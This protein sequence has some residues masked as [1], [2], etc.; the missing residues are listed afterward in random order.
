MEKGGKGV[1][2]TSW[3]M[4]HDQGPRRAWPI[5][6]DAASRLIKKA[7]RPVLVVGSAIEE[8]DGLIDIAVRVS[9]TGIPIAATG[10]SIKFFADKDVDVAEVNVVEITNM[11]T[12]PEW[13]GLDGQGKPDL[14][15]ILGVNLDLTNQTFSTLKNFTDI[16]GLNISR[17]YNTNATYSFPNLDNELWLEYLNQL[18]EKLESE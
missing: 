16:P 3:R 8:V 6:P 12:D 1:R 13:E 5:N 15:I 2:V 7:E 14:V 18:C 17:Y 10:H 4:G 11:L 9:K